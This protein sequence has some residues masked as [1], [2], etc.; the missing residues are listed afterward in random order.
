MGR[1][2]KMASNVFF[3]YIYQSNLKTLFRLVL[4]SRWQAIF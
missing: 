3:F 1:S 4:F 2:L